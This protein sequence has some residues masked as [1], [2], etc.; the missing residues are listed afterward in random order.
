MINFKYKFKFYVNAK[1][2]VTINS[3]KSNIHPHTWEVI[4]FLSVSKT[5]IINFSE[6]EN[7]LTHYFEA[8]E[9]KYLND[10]KSFE[11]I[12]PTMEHMA[13]IFFNEISAL[14]EN[15]DF[16]LETI[17]ISENPTR[18]YIISSIDD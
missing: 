4:T 12:E 16:N 18:T 17:E 7:N 13:C 1:H 2:N 14:I 11:N 8:F 15:K 3:K 6:F 5:E 9:G 10:L